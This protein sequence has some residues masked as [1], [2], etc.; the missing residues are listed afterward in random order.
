MPAQEAPPAAAPAEAPSQPRL[1]PLLVDY[2]KA[3]VAAEPRLDL[4]GETPEAEADIQLRELGELIQQWAS[5]WGLHWN[6][7]GSAAA[8]F[9]AIEALLPVPTKEDV[10]RRKSEAAA[11]RKA[12]AEERRSRKK[13]EGER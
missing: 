1:R 2:W 5:A 9:R 4:V 8:I 12:A 3:E 11:R 6:R 13:P 7:D 10:E